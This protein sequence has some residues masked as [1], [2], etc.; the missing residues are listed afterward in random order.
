MSEEGEGTG[1]FV[2]ESKLLSGLVWETPSKRYLKVTVLSLCRGISVTVAIVRLLAYTTCAC[3]RIR[4]IVQYVVLW[5]VIL[6]IDL[7][8]EIYHFDFILLS[9][10]DAHARAYT[11]VTYMLG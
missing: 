1:P 2:L 4:R 11:Y 8:Y 6:G 3:P 10:N 7:R 5:C 9:E